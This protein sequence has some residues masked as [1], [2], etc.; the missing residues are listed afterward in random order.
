[1]IVGADNDV[2]LAEILVAAGSDRACTVEYASFALSDERV[3][4]PSKWALS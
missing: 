2:Q 1:M 3:L 4:D